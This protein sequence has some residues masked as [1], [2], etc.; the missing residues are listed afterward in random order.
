MSI[1]SFLCIV[2]TV[3][4]LVTNTS[5]SASARRVPIIK[6]GTLDSL[7]HL[8]NDTTYVF[9]F[10]ATWC[11]PCVAEFPSFQ[12][13]QSAYG[14]S[15]L[16]VIFIS[17]DYRKSIKSVASF[18]DR[19]KV[20]EAVYLLDETD[21]NSWIDRVDSTWDGNLPATIVL[22]NAHNFRAFYPHDFSFDALVDAVKPAIPLQ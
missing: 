3:F 4:L 11:Q 9:N 21:Y 17:L 16:K 2:S 22:N 1:K 15:K 20:N 10:W 18:L 19:H 14:T 7:M 13:L 8:H 12:R 6:F 5:A